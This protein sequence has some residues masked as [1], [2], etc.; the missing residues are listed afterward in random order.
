MTNVSKN[1]LTVLRRITNLFGFII[2]CYY[3][4]MGERT[5]NDLDAYSTLHVNLDASLLNIMIKLFF[6][7]RN[8]FADYNNIR[9]SFARSR[10]YN[11][12]NA[13][14]PALLTEMC[15]LYCRFAIIYTH[16]TT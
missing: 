1:R 16:L 12:N 8:K 4:E 11:Y 10:A 6:L 7:A 14:G 9:V 3:S 5:F 13:A 2:G 15:F